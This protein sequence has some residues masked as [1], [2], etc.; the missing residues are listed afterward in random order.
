[1]RCI[2][3]IKDFKGI[4]KVL[5]PIEVFILL[6]LQNDIFLQNELFLILDFSVF[7]VI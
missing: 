7:Q 1:M 5:I 6:L 2:N 3:R 4:G